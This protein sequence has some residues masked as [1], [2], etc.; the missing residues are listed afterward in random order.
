[1][2]GLEHRASCR[3]GYLLHLAKTLQNNEWQTGLAAATTIEKMIPNYNGYQLS[4]K[5]TTRAA[6]LLASV[7]VVTYSLLKYSV[8]RDWPKLGQADMS[9]FITV[10]KTEE[11]PP[12]SAKAFRVNG[13]LVAVFHTGDG[14]YAIDDACP[15]MGASLADGHVEGDVV[16][17][18]WHAWRFAVCDGTWCDN[19]K[20]KIDSFNVRVT[21]NEL[22]V[23]VP[24]VEPPPDDLDGDEGAGD[25]G[26]RS[27]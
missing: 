12:G 11:I 2:L 21:G 5:S 15:H 4:V 24:D 8:L 25:E 26:Q 20:I 14:Y 23:S 6:R 17:C 1:M 22:Q 3:I 9:N 27:R 13:R 16:T 10:A 7:P 18:P 19:P